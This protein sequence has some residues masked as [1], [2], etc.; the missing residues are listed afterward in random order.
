MSDM[1]GK[2]LLIGFGVIILA[3]FLSLID[4]IY[5]EINQEVNDSDKDYLDTKFTEVSQK[6]NNFENETK[7]IQIEIDGYCT[8]DIS[9]SNYGYLNVTFKYFY[10]QTKIYNYNVA[11]NNGVEFINESNSMS[12]GTQVIIYRL[13][14]ILRVKLI[15]AGISGV[16]NN[17]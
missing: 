5:N 14:G 3:S 7:I 4:P 6:I 1:I 10:K 8:V 2:V 16:D 13:A 9:E 17:E 11:I 15:D 12:C